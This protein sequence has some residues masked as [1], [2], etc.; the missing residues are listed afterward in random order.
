MLDI[1]DWSSYL[2]DLVPPLEMRAKEKIRTSFEAQE[3]AA[4]LLA[5]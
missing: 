3:G 1:W 4:E 5:G 2:I